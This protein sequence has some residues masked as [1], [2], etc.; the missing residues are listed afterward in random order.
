M[1]TRCYC[2]KSPNYKR[3]GGRGIKVCERW[4]SF[5]LFTVDMGDRPEGMTLDRIDNDG[6][7]TPENCRWAT[8]KEQQRNT[9]TNHYISYEGRTECLV[10]WAE[11]Y[12][13]KQTTLRLRLKRGWDIGRALNTPV[14]KRTKR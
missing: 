1:H 8:L 14:R 4:H 11:E 5:E 9:R 10:T 2:K 12:D 7:Y 3:Y 13:I 6:D